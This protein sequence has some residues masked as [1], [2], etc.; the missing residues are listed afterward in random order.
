M[1]AA[2]PLP[3]KGMLMS[4]LYVVRHGQA[5]LFSEDY[6]RLSDLGLAQAEAL[7]GHWLDAGIEPDKVWSGTL[8]RQVRTAEAVGAVYAQ[9]GRRWPGRV[10]TTR[11]NEYP[12]DDILRTLGEHLRRRDPTIGAL[13]DAF[14]NATEP[15]ARYRRFHRLLAAVLSRWIDAHHDGVEVPLSWAEWS[16]GV[17]AALRDILADAG[18]GTSV[19]VFTSGGVIGVSV[20]TCLSAPEIKAAELNW[21]IHNCSVTQYTFSGE[22]VSLD[23]FNDVGHLPRELLTY[24]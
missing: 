18:R 12:A 23:R 7:A 9:R 1:T 2:T 11:L 3:R 4:D 6:D 8:T 15:A 19:A 10:T 24:R 16:G 22:R 14:D 13:A 20:Q 21:R 17:R 5:R